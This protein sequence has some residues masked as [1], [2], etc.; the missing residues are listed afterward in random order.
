MTTSEKYVSDYVY[1][2]VEKNWDNINR[3]KCDIRQSKDQ[4]LHS[5]RTN[6]Q[7]A[8]WVITEVMNWAMD[9][10]Y[11]KE[12]Q[13]FPAENENTEEKF[14]VIKLGDKYIK[15]EYL[16]DF[17]IKVSFAEKK[18]KTVTITYWE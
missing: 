8:I 16:E 18:T 5:V 6:P 3:Q 10:N 14:F 7:D 12:L 1:N 9:R 13:V 4:F 17:N 11:Y 15:Y 2:F